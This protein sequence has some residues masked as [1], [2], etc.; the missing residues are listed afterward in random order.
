[1]ASSWD[2]LGSSRSRWGSRRGYVVRRE[3]RKA[4]WTEDLVLDLG[5]GTRS[6]LNMLEVVVW[7]WRLG[8]V[9]GK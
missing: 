3:V 7:C 6:F 4:R 9:R 5:P 2:F 1:M 8:G